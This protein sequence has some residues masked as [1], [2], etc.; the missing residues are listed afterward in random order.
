MSFIVILGIIA[1]SLFA[2]T[3]FTRRRFGVLGLALCAGFILSTLWAADVTPLVREAGVELLSPPLASV[4]AATLVLLPAIILL[5]S[6][7]TYS[8]RLPRLLGSLAFALLAAALLLPSLYAGLVLDENGK[9]V[10]DILNENRNYIITAAIVYALFD[11]LTIK[12]P[13]HKDKEKE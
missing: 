8:K 2:A 7:P 10:Y 9:Q 6:G 13:K 4:V 12:T 5:F 1:A 11:I 3:Y